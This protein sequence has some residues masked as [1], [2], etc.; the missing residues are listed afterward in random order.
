MQATVIRRTISDKR[1][2]SGDKPYGPPGSRST[3]GKKTIAPRI[4][5][6]IA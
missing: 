6:A 1:C 4:H 5:D 3:T 2:V